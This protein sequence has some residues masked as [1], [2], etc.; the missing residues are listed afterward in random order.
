MS[1]PHAKLLPAS[2][3]AE[4]GV[5]CSFLLSAREV[6]SI[7]AER[8]LAREAFHSP[9]LASIY[10]VLVDLWEKNQQIDPV[11]LVQTLHDRNLLD[12]VGGSAYVSQLFTFLP[13]AANV[14][15]YL[16][17][18][19]E[20]RILREMI[21][22]GNEMAQRSYAEQEDVP[23]LLSAAVESVGAISA[24][25][26][27]VK[28]VKDLIRAKLDRMESGEP[29]EDILSTG[30]EKLDYYSP[31]RRGSMPLISGAPKSGKS[32]LAITIATHIA[33][34]APVLYFSLEDPAEEAVDR[35]SACMSRV[36]V[37]RHN[38]KSFIGNDLESLSRA[39]MR[40]SQMDLIIRD[41]VQ[42]L[43]SF[44]AVVRQTK[45]QHPTLAAV[46]LDYAQL[47]RAQTR[48]QDTREQ[49]V[50]KISRVCRLLSIEL[51]VAMIVL[52][53]ENED[54]NARESRSLEQDCTARWQVTRTEDD[55]VRILAI[56]FQRNGA[57]QVRFPLTFQ[58]H[59]SRFDNHA[60]FPEGQEPEEIGRKKKYSR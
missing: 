21:R 28:T 4:Q 10:A 1:E 44:G 32:M 11:T 5:I 3:D 8:H 14:G 25:R 54:G 56:P 30:L 42:D 39:L 45:A 49:E 35:V 6:G 59:I 46:V 7:C 50:A 24:P 40:M 20:K 13:T 55:K 19:E 22:V 17:V 60:G 47:L 37:V 43:G 31:L 33:H 26:R 53:Q 48:R 27:Q 15:R 34:S 36:P 38:A 58:G 18:M 16:E 2:P 57:S 29:S 9:A 52:S 51:K 12:Q 23:G 41:D